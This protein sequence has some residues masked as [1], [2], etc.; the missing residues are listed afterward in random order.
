MC[1]IVE[2]D[3][4]LVQSFL[5]HYVDDRQVL[6]ARL[7]GH[8]AAERGVQRGLRGD[9]ISSDPSSPDDADAGIVA[10][11]VDAQD[12]GLT[13]TSSVAL[14]GCYTRPVTFAET[15]KRYHRLEPKPWGTTRYAVKKGLRGY[16]LHPGVALLLRH[17]DLRAERFLDL[18]G[19]GGFVA[20][21]AKADYKTVLETSR[22]ALRCA[23]WTLADASDTQIVAGAP[24]DAS[25]GEADLV[26]LVPPTD[27][28]SARVGA[29][30]LGAHTALRP[31]GAAFIVMHKDGGA[32]RYEKA[33]AE[34]FGELEVVAKDG[35]WRLIRAT[36]VRE[37]GAAVLP[38]SFNAADMTLQAE[39]GVFAAGKL[40]PGT[41]RLLGAVDLAA[42]AGKRIFDL[43]C[44]Y[45]LIALKASLAG[46]A[47]TAADD[48]LL[49]VRS[50][51][52]NAQR[53]GVDVR[54]LHSDVDSEL[55]DELFDAVLMNPPFHVG[56][57]VVMDV[58]G[59]F[60][61]AAFERLRPGGVL[62]LV[63]NRALPYE[64]ELAR[65]SS[66]ETLFADAQFKVLRAV[67]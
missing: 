17:A 27:R 4:G 5:K 36:K 63:A 44:G 64:R 14:R 3:I 51:Y 57:Q 18:T 41:A 1:Y 67:R 25:P 15:L 33:V 31:G 32:K 48:D 24:W 49:A 38:V 50:T 58:P 16:P 8:D 2:R 20:L 30:L 19:S 22:A 23:A 54:P 55:Q 45:G 13:H 11:G 46:A 42:F 26:A 65:F 40:D 47:V 60:L 34:L 21:A 10:R 39:P 53:Y 29:E 6:A 62:V 52:Q 12:N 59:A 35:G 7:F 66:F 28:G 61:A 56:K 9:N 37:A 43:G